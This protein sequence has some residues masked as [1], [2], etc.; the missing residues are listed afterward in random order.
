MKRDQAYQEAALLLSHLEAGVRNDLPL[1]VMVDSL[2]KAADSRAE[3]R[4]LAGLSAALR[5]GDSMGQALSRWTAL[6]SKDVADWIDDAH[7]SGQLAPALGFLANDLSLVGHRRHQLR[8]HLIWPALLMLVATAVSLAVA[9][10]VIP[11]L[12]EAFDAFGLD[13][14]GP[15]TRLFSPA[16]D[17]P[18][19]LVS[20]GFL[21]LTVFLF[22]LM[23]SRSAWPSRFFRWLRLD[24]GLWDS[25]LQLR[26]LPLLSA[27]PAGGALA[28][29]ALKYLAASLPLFKQRRLLMQTHAGM[30]AG[31]SLDH[32]AQE[33]GLVP[34]S[35]LVHLDLAKRTD[36]M[37]TLRHLLSGQIQDRWEMAMAGFERR[38]S[39]LVYLL[40][41]VMV[42]H[43][44]VAVYLPIFRMGQML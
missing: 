13:L 29:P 26:L 25:E 8:L 41:V 9:I 21:I 17:L 36:N 18:V 37:P 33:T 20:V 42:Y 28:Q 7:A 31:T 15:T 39:W 35:L 44:L 2:E 30:V 4:R 27:T 14:P 19:P 12:T 1:Q 32:A 5:A 11:N 34:P 23:L 3:R 40:V 6:R 22:W 38:V 43:L 10:H 16:G 24:R